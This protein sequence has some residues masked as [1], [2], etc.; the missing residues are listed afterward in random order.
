MA[1]MI[2]GDYPD[3]SEVIEEVNEFLSTTLSKGRNSK[4]ILL[5]AFNR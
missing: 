1:T 5:A 4:L 3:L 2:Y